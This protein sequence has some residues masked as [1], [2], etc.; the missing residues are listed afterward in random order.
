MKQWCISGQWNFS[1]L[2]LADAPP[3]DPGPGEILLAMKAVSLNYRDTLMINRGY[4]KLSGEL[5][6]VPLSDGV[7]EVVALGEGVTGIDMGQRRLPC[8]NQLWL[9]GEQ[10]DESW[11]GT[12]GGPL[13]GTARQFMAARANATVPVPQHLSDAEA[14]TL[15]CAA[16]TAWN[17]L[18]GIE[19]GSTVVTQGTGGVS[20]FALQMA[21]ARGATVIATSSSGEKL[22]RLKDLGADHLLNYREIPDWGKAVLALSEGRGADLVVEIGGGETINQSLRAIR[23]GGTLSLIG[24]VSGS[25]A[26]INL[27]HVFMFHK[28]LIGIAT[29][30]VADFRAMMA[31]ISSTGLRPVIDDTVYDFQ[32]LGLG[33]A[34]KALPQGDHFGKVVVRVD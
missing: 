23:S 5:P 11:A 4:G 24:N 29:G 18:D 1:G 13:D 33:L 14:A 7:G 34:L 30:S 19:K 15:C 16:I 21:K 9:Q 27:P 25:V 10:H 22:E 2:A 17:A 20:L 12:L 3:P 26:E 6:L 8:F 28:R 31:E 32:D